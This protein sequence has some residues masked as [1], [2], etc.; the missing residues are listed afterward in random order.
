MKGSGYRFDCHS[1]AILNISYFSEGKLQF[2]VGH[3]VA[4]LI[5]TKICCWMLSVSLEININ[6]G[7]P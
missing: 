4:N 2:W 3:F 7:L 1:S 6:V 5:G